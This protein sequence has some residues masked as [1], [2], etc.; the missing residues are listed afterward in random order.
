MVAHA[1]P[2]YASRVGVLLLVSLIAALWTNLGDVIWWFHT[3]QYAAG[4][5][6]YTVVAGLLMALRHRRD[7]EASPPNSRG[8]T[9]RRSPWY[10]PRQSGRLQLAPRRP[11]R[12]RLLAFS[13]RQR[14]DC[15]LRR[16]PLECRVP[17]NPQRPLRA[18]LKEYFHASSVRPQRREPSHDHRQKP[19][20]SSRRHQQPQRALPRRAS[21][22]AQGNRPLG[23]RP[24]ARRPAQGPRE[25]AV[26]EEEKEEGRRKKRTP[27]PLRPRAPPRQGW[28]PPRVEPPRPP[29]RSNAHGPGLSPPQAA[30][31][32]LASS[33][34]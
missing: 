7:R 26:D 8:L 17:Y 30:A 20:N 5:I 13:V 23:R 16:R 1:L 28:P 11:V 22:K 9:A 24:I 29:P 15:T 4:Q 25:E 19:E 32:M 31:P 10:T 2:S 3:P 33:L 34:R 18:S 6:V 12:S 27:P 14:P 21:R